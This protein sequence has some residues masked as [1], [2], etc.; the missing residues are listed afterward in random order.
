MYNTFESFCQ[1]KTHPALLMFRASTCKSPFEHP[2]AL[3][4]ASVSSFTPGRNQ[5]ASKE[6]GLLRFCPDKKVLSI[7]NIGCRA[8]NI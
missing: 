4:T 3:L 1:I 8:A 2:A 5:K 6:E 7:P